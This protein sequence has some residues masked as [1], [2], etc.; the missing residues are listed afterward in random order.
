[1]GPVG[2]SRNKRSNANN[3]DNPDNNKNTDNRDD[4]NN[5]FTC[6]YTHASTIIY[7]H[8]YVHYL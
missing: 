8:I 1:M 3:Q 2:D 4:K 7:I 6:I 5:I